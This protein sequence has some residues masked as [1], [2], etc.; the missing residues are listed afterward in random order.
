MSVATQ[1]DLTSS[2]VRY[3]IATSIVRPP[4]SSSDVQHHPSS[5]PVYQTATF[6]L[7]PLDS[8]SSAFDYTRSGN[9]TRSHVQHHLTHIIPG[10]TNTFL[11]GSGMA[12]LDMVLRLIPAGSEVVAGE[13]LY[14]GTNRLLN[15]IQEM[16]HIKV[17]FLDLTHP[18]DTLIP[19]LNERTKMVIMESPSNPL[20]KITPIKQ[21]VDIVKGFNKECLVCCDN[22][23]MT[24]ILY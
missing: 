23:M 18:M 21:I 5:F 20:L 4:G 8:H 12:A 1:T 15:Y 2:P 19:I 3:R 6:H 22:T 16:N 10:A 17:H 11:V 14:G 24:P 7:N 13:D 9:P